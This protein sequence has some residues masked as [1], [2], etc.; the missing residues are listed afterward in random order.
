MQ[1]TNYRYLH[2]IIHNCHFI[3]NHYKHPGSKSQLTNDTSLPLCFT[4]RN[5]LATSKTTVITSHQGCQKI[6]SYSR[7][8]IENYPI[9]E[10]NT[11][12]FYTISIATLCLCPLLQYQMMNMQCRSP[13]WYGKNIL[14]I[15]IKLNSIHFTTFYAMCCV[16]STILFFLK[17]H[18]LIGILKF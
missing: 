18:I 1:V 14:I 17:F 5:W 10:E 12:N 2:T 16:M 4:V 13:I 9:I 6:L 3:L 8:C 11:D 15:Q 7:V